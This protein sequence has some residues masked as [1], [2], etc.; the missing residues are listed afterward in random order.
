MFEELF[1]LLCAVIAMIIAQALKP[2]LYYRTSKKLNWRWLISSG[3]FPSSH[4]ATVVA[5]TLAI[6][7]TN[8]FSSSLFAVTCTFGIIVI[9]DALNVRYY[10]GKNI[11]LT[12][13]LIHDLEIHTNIN[14][15]NPIYR[16][17]IKSI[18]GHKLKEVIGGFILGAMVTGLLYMLFF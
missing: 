16:E 11:E 6:G 12:K 9:Y 13:Q 5:L 15:D 17:K 1:P 10:A 14:F 4:S 3:G 8:H 2:L 18:L 7:I